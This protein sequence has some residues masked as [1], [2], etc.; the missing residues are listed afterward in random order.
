MASLS[1]KENFM[2]C[3]TGGVPEFVPRYYGGKDPYSYPRI[4]MTEA[5]AVT[6]DRVDERYEFGF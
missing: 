1:M 3:I 6:K 2:R 4:T 5:V